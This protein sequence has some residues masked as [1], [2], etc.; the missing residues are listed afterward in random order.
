MTGPD[1]SAAPDH[2]LIAAHGGRAM[3]LTFLV[4]GMGII[5]VVRA[6]SAA[7]DLVWVLIAPVYAAAALTLHCLVRIGA[8]GGLPYGTLG[9]SRFVLALAALVLAVM[10]RDAPSFPIASFLLYASVAGLCSMA[11]GAWIAMTRRHLRLSL[12]KTR[13]LFGRAIGSGEATGLRILSG[14]RL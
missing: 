10:E 11:D 14:G 5:T 13:A 4:L 9:D 3:F 6:P 12:V 8:A 2:A 1:R 7:H